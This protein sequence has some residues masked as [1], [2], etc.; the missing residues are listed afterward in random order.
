ME[1]SELSSLLGPTAPGIH[2]KNARAMED[3]A[4]AA[5]DDP[6]HWQACFR[7]LSQCG[8]RHA[9]LHFKAARLFSRLIRNGFV[10]V[11]RHMVNKVP[12]DYNRGHNL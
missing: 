6:F 7:I 3:H 4:R 10:N 12:S 2:R 9:L 8:V 11:R 1:I 5:R